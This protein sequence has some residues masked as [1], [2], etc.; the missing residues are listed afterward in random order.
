MGH[1]LIVAR[2]KGQII[3]ALYDEKRPLQIISDPLE[4]KQGIQMGGIY[5][6]KVKNIIKNINA[7]F[8]EIQE[9]IRCYLSL[10][11]MGAPVTL[12]QHADG[13]IHAGDELVVQVERE[14]IKTKLPSATIHFNLT[15]KY[16]VLVHG[17]Q[18]V[19]ISSKIENPQRRK[20]LKDFYAARIEGDYGF[21]VRTNAENASEPELLA[22]LARLL[23]RYQR[24][25]SQGKYRARFTV[26]EQP[27]PAYLCS[28]RD[29]YAYMLE[30]IVTDDETIFS[31]MQEYLREYQ[32][33]DAEKLRLYQEEL[34]LLR[35]Y[36]F[37]SRLKEALSPKVWLKSGASLVI[38]PTEA[39][40]VIDVNTGKAVKG[41]KS[42]E[43]YFLSINLEAAREIAYQLRLRNLSGIIII[44]FIDM[45][46][47]ESRKTLLAALQERLKADPVKTALVDMTPLNL[48]ELTRKKARKPL[49]EQFFQGTDMEIPKD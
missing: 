25:V 29:D 39:L 35:L 13:K 47:E 40:T 48:V 26:L 28:I 19:G 42:G 18:M 23:K 20:E 17:K 46:L 22:E 37:E 8:V 38:E 11:T 31:Q 30:E 49:H 21:I 41:R 7:A 6:G 9:G 33:E 44:D 14:E 3:S 15:G 5:L 1:K 34:P 45:K 16:V 12:Q 43:E 27:L 36:S 4:E 10:E 24:I 32:P 2:W